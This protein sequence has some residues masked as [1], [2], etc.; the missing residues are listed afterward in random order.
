M[1]SINSLLNRIKSSLISIENL[2]VYHYE[3]DTLAEAPY[4]VWMETGETDSFHGDNKKDEQVISCIVDLYFNDEFDSFV[5]E[6]QKVLNGTGGCAWRLSS[7]DYEDETKLIHYA[8]DVEL[9]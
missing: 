1:K 4:C 9:I 6:I 7:V 8:W 3:A 5:D 2:D